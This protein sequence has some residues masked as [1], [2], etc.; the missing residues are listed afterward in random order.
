MTYLERTLELFMP[1]AKHENI[2]K[3][4]ARLIETYSLETNTRLYGYGSTTYR[5]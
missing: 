4:I 5:K 2:K 1:S 3:T